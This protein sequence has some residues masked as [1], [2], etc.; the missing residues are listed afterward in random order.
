MR[1]DGKLSVGG[2]VDA[3]LVLRDDGVIGPN[4][5]V[6]ETPDCGR[7]DDRQLEI[8]E[9]AVGH[10]YYDVPRRPTHADIAEALDLSTNVGEHLRKNKARLLSKLAR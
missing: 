9:T 10:G 5:V 3:R 8:L 6:G 1:G 2:V 7:H 4:V